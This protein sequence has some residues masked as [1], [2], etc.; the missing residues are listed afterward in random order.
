MHDFMKTNS[1][2]SDLSAAL[3][4]SFS[5]RPDLRNGKNDTDLLS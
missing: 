3:L 1:K 5:L 4:T 2:T